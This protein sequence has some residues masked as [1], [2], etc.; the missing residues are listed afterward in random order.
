MSILDK[1]NVPQAKLMKTDPM[2]WRPPFWRTIKTRWPC[3]YH[4]LHKSRAE[5]ATKL[6]YPSTPLRI[7]PVPYDA[8]CN[9][10]GLNYKP[11]KQLIPNKIPCCRVT[12][13][14]TRPKRAVGH[15]GKNGKLL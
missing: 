1:S 4:N 10:G 14:F 9:H 6:F 7:H 12:R 15:C 11:E 5:K 2:S 3:T 13:R 8:H